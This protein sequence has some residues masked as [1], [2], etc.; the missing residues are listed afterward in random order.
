MKLRTFLL[1]ALLAVPLLS[2]C[3][4]LLDK[5]IDSLQEQ[6]DL[7]KKDVD[8]ANQT[9]EAI[10]AVLTQME[11]GGRIDST[12]QVSEDGRTG[13][14]IIFNDGSRI[15][16]WN[17]TD[18]ET[19]EKGAKG[20]TPKIS[21][22]QGDDGL[23]YWT[24]DGE[25]L[26]DAAGTRIRVTGDDG[27]SVKLKIEDRNWYLSYGDEWIYMGR[28]AG[29]DGKPGDQGASGQ[30]G[31]A[32]FRSVE[33]DGS[34]LVLTFSDGSVIR[35]SMG[36]AVQMETGTRKV[37][38]NTTYTFPF[39]VEGADVNTFAVGHASPGYHAEVSNGSLVVRTPADGDIGTVTLFVSDGNG[40]IASKSVTLDP[41]IDFESAEVKRICV[42]N[43]DI[44]NDGE[45]SL[46]EARAVRTLTMDFSKNDQITSFDELRYF[47]SLTVLDN[48][49]TAF[50]NT[51]ALR[52]LT[53]P[54]SVRDLS[55]C[56]LF[57]QQSGLK[58]LT[59][60]SVTPP[61]LCKGFFGLPLTGADPTA[62][63]VPDQSVN[64]YKNAEYWSD[65][66]SII[67]PLSSK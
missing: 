58:T 42:K 24:L 27:A 10:R 53:F 22:R 32:F 19:G 47:K 21:V 28:A 67:K 14:D 64:L 52:S 2:G 18:G 8:S 36:I 60:L 25:W 6:L 50:Y 1:T 51:P 66:A 37:R 13:Y 33:Q 61:T 34:V 40:Y 55:H 3:Q 62:I 31:S 16:L 44:D 54:S 23:W 46:I 38:W 9:I 63:Y 29:A 30:G 59:V 7:L 4:S 35:L 12:V 15:R 17:G 48:E 20:E 39:T 41:V 43:W 11:N 49:M 57:F 26:T 65:Y 45:L 5:E 56:H